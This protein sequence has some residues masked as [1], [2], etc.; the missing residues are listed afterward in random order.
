MI[1]TTDK[2]R[3]KKRRTKRRRGSY[4]RKYPAKSEGKGYKNVTINGAPRNVT[5]FN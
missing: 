5:F 1:P 3:R 2:R 4:A